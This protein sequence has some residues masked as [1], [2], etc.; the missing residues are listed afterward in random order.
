[1]A[2]QVINIG[3]TA[4]DG[5][6][7][8]LRDAFDKIND[9]FTENYTSIAALIAG[10]GGT[11]GGAVGTLDPVVISSG[12][13]LSNGDMTATSGTQGGR[14][15]A[16]TVDSVN[17]GKAGIKFSGTSSALQNVGIGIAVKGANPSYLGDNSLGWYPASSGQFLGYPGGVGTGTHSVSGQTSIYIVFDLAIRKAWVSLD[18]STYYGP[19]GNSGDPTTGTNGITLPSGDLVGII[20]FQGSGTR[21]ITVDL[22][23]DSWL[24]SG[25]DSYVDVVGVVSTTAPE[26]ALTPQD[27]GA[28]ADGSNH[29]VSA[30]YA[31]L[32][33]AQAAYDGAYFF[34]TSTNVQADWA[35]CQ[36]MIYRA[37]GPPGGEHGV[38]NASLNKRMFF[39][40]GDYWLG[41]NSLDIKNT[42]GAIFDGAG[43]FAVKIRADSKAAFKFDGLWYTQISNFSCRTDGVSTEGAM[44]VDGNV[45]GHAYTTRGVQGVT[46]LNM[47][48]DGGNGPASRCFEMTPL[49]ASG[50]QGSECIWINCHFINANLC[51][52]QAGYN[53]LSNTFIGGNFQNYVVGM[54]CWGG[55]FSVFNTGFQSIQ[56]YNQIMAGDDWG[57]DIVCGNP[58]AGENISIR[59][60]RTE[61]AKFLRQFAGI[62]C[63]VEGVAQNVAMN[64]WYPSTAYGPAGISREIQADRTAFIATTPGT[65]GTVE[66]NWAAVAN[67]ATVTD[68]TITWTRTDFPW[69]K[70]N[71][72]ISID[73]ETVGCDVGK[74]EL[75]NPQLTLG[76]KNLTTATPYQIRDHEGLIN[77]DTTNSGSQTATLPPAYPGRRV[78][79]HKIDPTP[80]VVMIRS[81][82][83][84]E[85]GPFN[86]S[87]GYFEYPF[88]SGRPEDIEFVYSANDGG[89]EVRWRP[90]RHEAAPASVIQ[91]ST[92]YS[93]SL[94]SDQTIVVDTTAASRNVTLPTKPGENTLPPGRTHIIKKKVAANT[95][96]V[97]RGGSV[98]TIDGAT[99]KALTAQYTTLIVQSDGTN[100]NIIG[101]I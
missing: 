49:G 54:Y 2:K 96:N 77:C 20:D 33:D 32:G 79:F 100:W 61:S 95:V 80:N 65:S 84:I 42:V 15:Y 83:W 68:G 69:L 64:P 38:S 52:Y 6:G 19:D 7:D 81:K 30:D 9:N 23:G 88:G 51:Y 12:V 62:S 71:G 55:T 21:A 89:G 16:R 78:L 34:L 39:P 28:Y 50:G 40:P 25:Y 57:Y 82:Q 87:T 44:V 45:P 3:S 41:G 63:R 22:S 24:P 36:A 98:A 46:F 47:E 85:G 92:D 37:L 99:T 74:I 17:T 70:S 56:F 60:C 97:N 26:D 10:S 94:T 66:P 1:M 76:M 101:V 59:S 53:A 93:A 8:P 75:E 67:G 58:G 14:A 18:A 13:T 86:G 43:R 48:F 31:T 27:F 72:G 29:L 35:A 90:V 91:T 73:F 4:N 11:G 5:T